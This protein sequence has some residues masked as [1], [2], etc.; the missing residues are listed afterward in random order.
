VAADVRPTMGGS[1][2]PNPRPRV[3]VCLAAV[4]LIWGSTYLAIR[5]VVTALPPLLSAGARYVAAGSALYAFLRLRGA[6][7]P[8][9]RQWIHTVPAGALLFL[10]G[11]GFVSLAEQHVSSGLAAVACAATPL[12]ACLMALGFGERPSRREWAGLALG[13]A[14]VVLLAA[15]DLRAASSSGLLLLFAP[16][17]WALGSVLSRRLSLPP[18]TMAAASQMIAGGLVTL[19]AALVHGERLPAAIPAPAA[20][21]FAYL[22]VF[23]SIVGFSAFTYLLRHT[24]TPLAMSYAYVNPVIAVLLGAALGGEHPSAGLY[25]PGALVVLGVAVVAWGKAPRRA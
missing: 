19:A 17:G 21:A 14:G 24:T 8:S 1:R 13:F 2:P 10:V 6:P 22:A 7:A 4:Y 9:R 16:A 23:G 15:G 20:L 25:A 18:G 11:N 5:H 12:F 3:A